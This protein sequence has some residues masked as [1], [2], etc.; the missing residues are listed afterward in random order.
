[1]NYMP[2]VRYTTYGTLV[3]EVAL[4]TLVFYKPTRK[5]AVLGGILLHAYIE[6]SMNIPQFSYAMISMYVCFYS[7]EE[8]QAWIHRQRTRFA[9]R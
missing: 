5:W 6:Y 4:G 7:G 9:T 8:V 2:M 1:M 3:V